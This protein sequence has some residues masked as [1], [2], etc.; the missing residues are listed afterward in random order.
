MTLPYYVCLGFQLITTIFTIGGLVVAI[1]GLKVLIAGG[2]Y[3]KGLEILKGF[4][5][6]T[7]GA[8]IFSIG[9]MSIEIAF[10]IYQLLKVGVK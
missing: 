4:L 2:Q 5:I 1:L 8:V 9:T 3:A 6:T 10:Y 7:I